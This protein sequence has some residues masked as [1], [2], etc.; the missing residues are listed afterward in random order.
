MPPFWGHTLCLGGLARGQAL[1]WHSGL[2]RENAARSL[3]SPG[4]SWPRPHEPLSS[5]TYLTRGLCTGCALGP[6]RSSFTLA[7]SGLPPRCRLGRTLPATQQPPPHLPCPA[8][9]SL[10]L[11]AGLIFSTADREH[12]FIVCGPRPRSKLRDRRRLLLCAV[13]SPEQCRAQSRFWINLAE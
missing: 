13:V 12:V 9:R 5:T 7:S 6:D 11:L 4:L 1:G 2:C 10:P 3:L 8:L